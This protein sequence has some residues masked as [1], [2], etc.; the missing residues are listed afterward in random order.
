[1]KTYMFDD[2]C[3]QMQRNSLDLQAVTA[4]YLKI[5]IGAGFSNFIAVYDLDIKSK[6]VTSSL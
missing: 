4:T 3:V 1:M 2:D 6:T 5:V